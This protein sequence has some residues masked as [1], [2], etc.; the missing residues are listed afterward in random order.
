M[1]IGDCVPF[2]AISAAC[3]SHA[4]IEIEILGV[5]GSRA[6]HTVT[7]QSLGDIAAGLQL[8]GF[9]IVDIP[10]LFSQP[11]GIPSHRCSM[12]HEFLAMER[13]LGEEEWILDEID[14]IDSAQPGCIGKKLMGI[15]EGG[16][17]F[18]HEYFWM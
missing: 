2:D 10:F 15:D 14:A 12:Q 16:D 6:G 8:S 18:G 13:I 1:G 7:L 9:D 3:I 5:D 4:S 17:H 11:I